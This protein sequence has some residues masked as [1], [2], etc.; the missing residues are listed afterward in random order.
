MGRPRA[1]QEDE[2]QD[3]AEEEQAVPQAETLAGQE[4]SGN[5]VKLKY[6]GPAGQSVRGLGELE[7]GKSYD[8]PEEIADGLVAGSAFWEEA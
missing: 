4:L 7:S 5:T 1:Q 3:E 6:K 8:V 2:P